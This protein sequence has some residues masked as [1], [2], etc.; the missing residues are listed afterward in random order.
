MLGQLHSCKLFLKVNCQHLVFQKEKMILYILIITSLFYA[1]FH[2]ITS[3]FYWTLT[4]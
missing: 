2:L 3:Y 1:F 4:D